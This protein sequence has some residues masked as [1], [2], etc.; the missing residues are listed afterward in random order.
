[1]EQNRVSIVWNHFG[2]GEL[3]TNLRE[4]Y[5]I[6]N[7]RGN[8]GPF[9][10]YLGCNLCWQIM[11]GARCG[12]RRFAILIHVNVK[13]VA[14]IKHRNYPVPRLWLHPTQK[15]QQHPVEPSS[16]NN[17]TFTALSTTTTANTRTT[18][19]I[20]LQRSS[21]CCIQFFRKCYNTYT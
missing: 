10:H 17:T 20:L 18:C 11:F 12:G 4:C 8:I 13:F 15:Q 14:R 6:S 19:N 2:P 9:Q 16:Y 7:L 3:F 5:K 1:M 21:P